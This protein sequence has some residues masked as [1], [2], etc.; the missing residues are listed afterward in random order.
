MTKSKSENLS[1]FGPLDELVKFF[2]MHDLG[3]Y[4]TEMPEAYFEVDIK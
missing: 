2:D 3:E 4:W 1:R